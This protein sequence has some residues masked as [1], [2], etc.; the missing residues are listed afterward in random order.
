MK[1]VLEFSIL[2]ISL[3]FISCNKG[4]SENTPN[5]PPPQPPEPIKNTLAKIKTVTTGSEKTT[6]VYD[7][8]GR[9][10][11]RTGTNGDLN[12]YIYEPAVITEKQRFNGGQLVS[13]KYELNNDGNATRITLST[14]PTSETVIEYNSEKWQTVNR[15]S[16]PTPLLAKY[17]VSGGKCDSV[18]YCEPD[19]TWKYSYI[20]TFY[21]DQPIVNSGEFEG[22]LFLGKW[23]IKML[24]S[25]YIRTDN[26]PVSQLVTYT[27]EY[28]AAGLLTK[29]T[30]VQG[31]NTRTSAYTYY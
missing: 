14:S 25:A 31:S 8:Y 30:R 27:Y 9:I 19:G 24:K 12:E 3:L 17:F 5:P 7:Q 6:Y 18:W 11:S 26:S 16:G 28:D 1:P 23:N 10:K 22:I 20:Q 2:I 13:R 4:D 29:E 21:D 15:F